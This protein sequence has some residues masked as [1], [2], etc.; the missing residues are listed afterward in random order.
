M[1]SPYR[2][3]RRP[4]DYADLDALVA[5]LS[6]AFTP[7]RLVWGSGW[8][9]INTPHAVSFSPLQAAIARWFPDAID[10]RHVLHGT[11]DRLFFKGGPALATPDGRIGSRCRLRSLPPSIPWLPLGTGG[12]SVWR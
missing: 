4:D 8:P 6:E 10:R 9:F 7:E 1:T 3:S 12:A 5:L 11:A 2:L